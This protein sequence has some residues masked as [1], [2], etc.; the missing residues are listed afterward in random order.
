MLGF[1]A[2]CPYKGRA[3]EWPPL[4]DDKTKASE[5]KEH[6]LIFIPRL[7]TLPPEPGATAAAA[8]A[9]TAIFITLVNLRRTSK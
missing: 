1:K 9:P 4:C 8:P 5:Q 6:G 7:T 2:A 3:Q